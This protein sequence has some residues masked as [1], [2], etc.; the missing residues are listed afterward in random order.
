MK[1]FIS[2]LA[3]LFILGMTSEASAITCYKTLA[4]NNSSTTGCLEG[5]FSGWNCPSGWS[6]DYK[7]CQCVMPPCLQ[8]NEEVTEEDLGEEIIEASDT[9][10]GY[11][12]AEN[13]SGF[14]RTQSAMAKLDVCFGAGHQTNNFNTEL[15]C[16]NECAATAGDRN[17][18]ACSQSTCESRC[19]T[20]Y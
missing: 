9:F 4:T 7:L 13:K 15:D 6:T 2:G 1:T 12:N 18:K 3:L 17:D 8:G 19:A 10:Y 11:I 20:A 14:G 16:K 5:Q